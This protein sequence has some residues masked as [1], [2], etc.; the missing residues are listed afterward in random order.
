MKEYQTC[1]GHPFNHVR[2]LEFRKQIYNCFIWT[3]SADWTN[4]RRSYIVSV[5][6]LVFVDCC[7]SQRYH[8]AVRNIDVVEDLQYI[9]ISDCWKNKVYIA[10]ILCG[11][12]NVIHKFC[13]NFHKSQKAILSGNKFTII[14]YY[15]FYIY[16]YV[17]YKI[18][19][20]V[21][22]ST[23]AWIA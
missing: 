5:S 7:R 2:L 13:F 6:A 16:F 11:K 21:V 12:T 3:R 8:V 15:I 10:Y 1:S 22:Q 19:D 9:V 14:W 4:N 20:T 23:R 17:I 18:D